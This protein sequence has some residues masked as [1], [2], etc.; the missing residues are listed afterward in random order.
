MSLVHLRN[1]TKDNPGL[2]S[3]RKSGSGHHG[4]WQNTQ[5]NHSHATIHLPIQQ[6]PQTRGLEGYGS[7]SSAAQNLQRSVSMENVKQKVKT[8]FILQGTL[9]KLAEDMS[10]TDTLQRPYRNHKRLTGSGKPTRIPSRFTPLRHQ[11]V[12]NQESPLFT[13]LGSFQEKESIKR[14]EQELFQP[15]SE[16][17]RANDPE[18]VGL[19]ERSTQEPEIAVNTPDKLSSPT[20]ENDIPTQNEHSIVRPESNINS[21][22]I[23]L[24]VS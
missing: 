3:T 1:Q 20:I 13:I 12:S 8:R 11:Q 19:S 4:G 23:W 2:F 16:R 17:V 21:N 7:S 5:G 6:E 10:Q 9:G 14:K 18:A 15:Y 22:E 24:K